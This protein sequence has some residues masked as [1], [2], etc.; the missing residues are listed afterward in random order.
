MS[1]NADTITADGG[2]ETHDETDVRFQGLVQ[3]PLRAGLLRF[4]AGHPEQSFTVEAFMQSFGRMRAPVDK[5]I[6]ELGGTV[7]D[8]AWINHTLRASIPARGLPDLSQLA[9]VRVL[10]IPHKLEAD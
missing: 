1:T 2:R 4:L 3:S 6:S 5:T 10:D 9:T 7:T 8:G